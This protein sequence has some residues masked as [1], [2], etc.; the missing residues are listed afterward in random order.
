M[1]DCPHVHGEK[2]GPCLCFSTGGFCVR[3]QWLELNE[4][5]TVSITQLDARMTRTEERLDSMEALAEVRDA[6][7]QSLLHQLIGLGGTVT[8][9]ARL[10]ESAAAEKALRETAERKEVAKRRL[11]ELKREM[12]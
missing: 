11:T 4:Q 1:A 9:G 12:Q 7:I 8:S 10:L 2:P 3:S 6:N 5:T